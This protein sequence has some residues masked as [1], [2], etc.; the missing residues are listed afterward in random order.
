MFISRI[1]HQT[2]IVIDELSSGSQYLNFCLDKI[3]VL[4]E[5]PIARKRDINIGREFF[6]TQ[7]PVL[8][9]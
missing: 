8:R 2:L 9:V 4:R 6:Y 5:I 7:L 3:Q 1:L